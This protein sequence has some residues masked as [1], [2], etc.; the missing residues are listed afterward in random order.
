MTWTG[1]LMSDEE[2]RD[3]IVKT[4]GCKIDNGSLFLSR[5]WESHSSRLRSSRA[6]LALKTRKM[7]SPCAVGRGSWDYALSVGLVAATWL[8]RGG[9]QRPSMRHMAGRY[10]W[11]NR[12]Q[13]LD[14]MAKHI[15]GGVGIHGCNAT[16]RLDAWGLALSCAVS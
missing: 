15:R 14:C 4:S 13:S 6:M 5:R 1:A 8:L 11:G 3:K 9:S 16:A 7:Q 10:Q 12:Q 2:G